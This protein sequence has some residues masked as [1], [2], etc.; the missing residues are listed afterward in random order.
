MAPSAGFLEELAGNPKFELGAGGSRLL[1]G[2]SAYIEAAEAT[3]AD[4]HSGESALLFHSGFEANT[5]IMAAI[6]RPEMRLFLMRCAM[7]VCTRA[8]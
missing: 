1:N 4:F 5:A 8:C 7:P 3:I 6:P 2:N